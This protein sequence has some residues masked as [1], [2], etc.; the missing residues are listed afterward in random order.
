[1]ANVLT[2]KRKTVHK[3]NRPPSFYVL[4]I[5]CTFSMLDLNAVQAA[6]LFFLVALILGLLTNRKGVMMSPMVFIIAAYVLGYPLVILFPGLYGGLWEGASPQALE[7]GMLWALRG[8]CA[9]G[10]GYVLVEQFGNRA[11]KN[12]ARDEA[13][14]RVRICYTVY[15]LTCIGW[16]AMLAWVAYVMIFGISLT[17]IEGSTVSVDSAAGTLQQVLTL[18]SGLRNPF[19]LGF[20]ILHFWKKTDRHLVLLC[21]ALLVI[22]MVEIVT[23]GSKASIISGLVV[24]LLALAF[25]PIRLNLKQITIGLTILVCVYGSF[26]VITEYRAIMH[27]EE[28][29][30]RDVFD[31][32]VQAESFGSAV[33]ASLPFSESAVGRRTKVEKENVFRR[34]GD[35]IFSFSALMGHTRWQPPYEHAWESL[36][37]PAYSIAPRALITDKPFFFDSDRNAREYYRWSY[38]GMSVTLLGSFYFAWGYA[39]IIFGMAFI[40]GILSYFVKKAGLLGIYSPDWLILLVA[41]IVPLLDVGVTF[42]AITANVIRVAIILWLLHLIYPLVRGAMRRRLSRILNPIQRG[43]NA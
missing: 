28:T 14:Y 39:G 1:M 24:G 41:L 3:N 40:G 27:D 11:G 19:F 22:S 33:M 15:V 6:M 17:F 29:A 38:G 16:L 21:A 8:F 31:F 30:G 5:F 12:T 32:A 18:L 43:G 2:H 26:A 37:V 7:Y 25:L 4:A 13:L 42:Q 9:F 20:L 23:I 36:M 34:F 10:L 35:G